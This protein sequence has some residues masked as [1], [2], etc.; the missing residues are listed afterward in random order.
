MTTK[1][2]TRPL[3]DAARAAASGQFVQLSDGMTH[4]ELAGPEDGPPVT[5]VHGFSVPSYIWDPTFAALAAA[6]MRVLRYDLFGRGFSDR[7]QLRYDRELFDR[8]L[9]ELLDALDFPRPTGLAGLSMGGPIVAVYTQRRPEQVSRLALLDPAGLALPES[10]PARLVKLPLIGDWIMDA[11]GDKVLLGNL[12]KDIK[13]PSQ[14]ESYIERFKQQMAFPGFKRALL[15]TMRS[16]VLTHAADA[17]AAVGKLPIP[18]LLIWGEEDEVVP[19]HLSETLRQLIPQAR[20]HA[21]PNAGHVPSL[22]RPAVVNPLLISFFG[23]NPD[24]R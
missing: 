13:D 24:V 21:I 15:S 16:G 22:E 7:P 10:L 9:A 17:Y 12:R 6:G 1:F 11:V 2:E 18:V 19:Y 14:V 3:D 20:F 4:Y 23:V 8:Q 5:L